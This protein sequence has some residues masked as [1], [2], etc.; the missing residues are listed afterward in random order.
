MLNLTATTT[1][2]LF[3]ESMVRT[4]VAR[5]LIL[6]CQMNTYEEVVF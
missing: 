3:I 2:T 4:S 6:L 1:N 5:L